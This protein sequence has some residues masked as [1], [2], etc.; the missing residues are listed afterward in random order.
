MF[1][2][3]EIAVP[4]MRRGDAKAAG[5]LIKEG[6]LSNLSVRISKLRPGFIFVVRASANNWTHTGILLSIKEQTFD[7]LEGNPGGDGGSDGANAR[8]GNRNFS[9]KDFIRLI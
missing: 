9:S 3:L 1:E 8:Q 6:E 4:C 5:R 7:T 2:Q